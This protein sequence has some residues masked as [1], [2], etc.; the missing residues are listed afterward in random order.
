MTFE[1]VE[2]SEKLENIK[3]MKQIIINP[4]NNGA[5]HSWYVISTGILE[6]PSVN[7]FDEFGSVITYK[8]TMKLKLSNNKIIFELVEAL[9]K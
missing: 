8:V 6:I 9:E 3:S 4:K 7:V 2:Y 1:L 5:E